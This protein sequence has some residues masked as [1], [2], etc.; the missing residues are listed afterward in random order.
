M[1]AKTIAGKKTLK[2]FTVFAELLLW[3]EGRQGISK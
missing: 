3:I 2:Y 1:I